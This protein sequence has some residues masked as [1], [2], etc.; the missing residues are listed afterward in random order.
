MI[1]I[2][3]RIFG[4]ILMEIIPIGII[5]FM[6]VIY[7]TFIPNHWGKLTLVTIAIVAWFGGKF[8]EKF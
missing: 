5:V 8:N 2:I 6:A 1:N 3:K 4:G 7:V